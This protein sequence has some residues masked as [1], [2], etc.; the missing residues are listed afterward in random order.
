MAGSQRVFN[1]F[2]AAPLLMDHTQYIKIRAHL[3]YIYIY[4]CGRFFKQHRV[5]QQ[6]RQTFQL[7]LI[8][9]AKFSVSIGK[10]TYI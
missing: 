8:L 5:Y 7:L 9:T 6:K 4:I 3:I 2:P 10:T 1:G